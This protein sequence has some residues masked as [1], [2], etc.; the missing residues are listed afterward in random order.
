MESDQYTCKFETA[1]GTTI[2]VQRMP[3]EIP[4]AIASNVKFGEKCCK[5]HGPNNADGTPHVFWGIPY[6]LRPDTMFLSLSLER[7]SSLNTGAHIWTKR[8]MR[9]PERSLFLLRL[10]FKIDFDVDMWKD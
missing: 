5:D 3:T 2:F 6:V 4:E 1:K 9:R 10:R 7:S 8:V